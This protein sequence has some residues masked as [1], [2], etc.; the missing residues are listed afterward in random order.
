MSCDSNITAPSTLKDLIDSAVDKYEPLPFAKIL[1]K[2]IVQEKSFTQFK[3]DVN[4]I[5][6][7]VCELSLQNRNIAILGT[8]TYEWMAAYFGIA[9]AGAVVVPIDKDLSTDDIEVLLKQTDITNIIFDVSLKNTVKKLKENMPEIEN[10]ISLQQDSCYPS[11]YSRLGEVGVEFNSTVTEDMTATIVF[12]SGTTGYNKGVELSHKNLCRDVQY[13]AYI[14]GNDIKAGNHVFSILPTHHMFLITTGILSAFGFGVCICIGEGLKYINKVMQVFKPKVLLTVPMVIENLYSRIMAEAQKKN[15]HIQLMKAM[16]YSK[17][18]DDSAIDVR[19]N[20]FKDFISVFGG[21]LKVVVCGG[22]S[23]RHELV[24]DFNALGIYL[25]S[26]YGITECS[27]VVAC[28]SSDFRK[29][30]SVGRVNSSGYC[31]VKVEDGEVMVSGDIVMRGYYHDPAATEESFDG[32]W[33]KTG[34]LGR[35]DEDG[36]LFLT[37]RKKD[38]IILDDGNNISPDELEEQLKKI[39]LIKDVVIYAKA[40]GKNSVIAAS[41]YPNFEYC[42]GLSDSDLKEKIEMAVYEVS[43]K[44]ARYKQVQIIELMTKEFDKTSLGKIKRYKVIQ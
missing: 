16:E 23:L 18:L 34:D 24:E 37:G 5:S 6:K 32:I 8:L 36:F 35:I 21:E 22:A 19:R 33:F 1:S 39:P 9:C 27:P 30:C 14:L 38:I 7:M 3:S 2:G 40:V 29:P 31:K 28:N 20:M 26:G 13:A 43:S 11:I 4:V 25:L 41:V 15:V 44:W 10:M 17:T 42:N 12:T